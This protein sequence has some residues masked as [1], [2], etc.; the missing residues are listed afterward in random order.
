MKI[1][2]LCVG[3][4]E[5]GYL[6][7]GIALYMNRL[8]HYVSVEMILLPDLKKAGT[9]PVAARKRLEGEAVYKE[10]QP[11]DFL[12]LLDE[13]GKL[14]SSVEFAGELQKRMNSGVKRVV[15]VVGGAFGFSEELYQRAQMKLSLSKMTFSH[16]M[17][18][19]FFVEQL[20]RAF[21]ILKGEP[22]HNE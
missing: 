21:T 9:L 5:K 12:V 14:L 15:F 10:L 2:I 8:K 1:R 4:T 6:E 13:R 22:Y 19:L 7:G 18:R 16:Q 11:D 20:Y 3:K 17:V